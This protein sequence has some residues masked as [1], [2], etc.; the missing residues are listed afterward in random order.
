MRHLSRASHCLWL[1]MGGCSRENTNKRRF[2]NT[3]K[4]L[5]S[6]INGTFA[7]SKAH[8]K[9]N[10]AGGWIA[11][12]SLLPRW[13]VRCNAE[14]YRIYTCETY[15]NEH[16]YTIDRRYQLTRVLISHHSPSYPAQL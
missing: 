6:T 11:S 3:L 12:G 8:G 13:A 16:L 5:D 4:W 7:H 15:R 10:D 14:C 9:D 1:L 2:A